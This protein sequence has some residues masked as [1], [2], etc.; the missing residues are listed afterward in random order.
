MEIEFK[1]ETKMN[2]AWTELVT[3]RIKSKDL[4]SE[5]IKK[6]LPLCVQ[7]CGEKPRVLVL[8]R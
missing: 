2:F 7:Q 6:K 5:E 3:Y 1:T 8:P 4:T